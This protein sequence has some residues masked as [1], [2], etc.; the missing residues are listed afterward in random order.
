MLYRCIVD[1][2]P[3][4]EPEYL[5]QQGLLSIIIWVTNIHQYH[6]YISYSC[7]FVFQQIFTTST[8]CE[9]V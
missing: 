3:G 7:L 6:L 9:L 5:S 1:L 8:L 2:E 4:P